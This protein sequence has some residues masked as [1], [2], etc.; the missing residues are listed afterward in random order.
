MP[1]L[2]PFVRAATSL[3]AM[4]EVAH[5]LLR[6]FDRDNLSL[7]QLADLVARDNALAA[8]VLRSAN[9]A[10]YSPGYPVESLSDA[11]AT[12]GMCAMRD[13]TMASCLTG[14]L[15]PVAGFDRIK[16]W[17][18]TLG[19]ATYATAIAKAIGV[20]EEPAYVAGLMLRTGQI[21]M[22]M[23]NPTAFKT[24]T[25]APPWVD[26]RFS[27]ELA[28]FGVAHGTVTAA[29]ARCWKFPPAL[30]AAFA[31]ADAPTAST[32]INSM[33]ATLRL[34]SVV[35]D[36]RELG[37]PVAQ[38]LLDTQGDLAAVLNLDVAALEVRLP[39]HQIATAGA[40]TLIQ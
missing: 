40:D 3:P 27:A 22:A 18:G 23:V 12:L 5:E 19:V 36:C 26:G 13:L 9:S 32:P 38:G 31:A 8:K 24:V 30:V 33:G 39:D 15:P 35:N 7:N 29:L 28:A 1:N 14:A 21:L 17:R 2:E 20:N 16:F 37:L 25:K 4:P 11:A 6:S 10:R 34:A